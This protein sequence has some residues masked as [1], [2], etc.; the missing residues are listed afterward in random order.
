MRRL[1]IA[2][3]MVGALIIVSACGESAPVSQMGQTQ[4][5]KI[6]FSLDGTGLGERIATIALSDLGGQPIA[7]EQ[8]AVLPTMQQMGMTSPEVVAQQVAPGRYQAKSEFF[9]MLGDWEVGVRVKDRGI[10]ETATFK[11][12]ATP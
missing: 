3:F 7:A 6:Q 11:I 9:T 1:V 5:Y 8:V 4:R 10:E 12:H 2:M